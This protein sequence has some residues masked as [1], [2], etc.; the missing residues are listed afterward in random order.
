MQVEV[1]IQDYYAETRNSQAENL[2]Q[3]VHPAVGIP[4][5]VWQDYFQTW[6]SLLQPDQSLSQDWELS[7]RL[8]DDTEIQAL[9]KLYRHQDR[10][11]DVLAFAALEVE[12]PQP[13]VSSPTYLGDILIS[14]E[15]AQTQAQAR[16][17][18]LP[19]E[20]AWLAAHGLLHL[21]GWDHPDQESLQ[22][23][24]R[25]QHQLLAAVG[26]QGQIIWT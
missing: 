25:K 23:M 26:L 9:N 5:Q 11:T 14:V 18:S 16:E 8:T 21:L 4:E 24:L 19:L 12:A 6:L 7:L 1:C 22:Q 15:T 17:H 3:A 13:Q 10:S 20:L 2:D